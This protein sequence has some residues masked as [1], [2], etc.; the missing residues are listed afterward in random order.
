MNKTEINKMTKDI[1]LY[2]RRCTDDR[3]ISEDTICLLYWIYYA[4]YH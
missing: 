3:K 4:G 1:K 2:D